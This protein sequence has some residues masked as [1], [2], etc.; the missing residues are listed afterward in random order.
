MIRAV[1]AA[2]LFLA[3]GSPLVAQES[4]VAIG[5][6]NTS[7]GLDVEANTVGG[8]VAS[9]RPNTGEYLVTVTATDA[10]VGASP[11]DFL[12]ETTI[13]A[14]S[15]GDD[16]SNGAVISVTDDVLTVRVRVADVED[17]GSVSAAVAVNASFF[18]VIRRV[19][20]LATV[21]EG[22]TRFLL[23]AGRMASS[24]SLV[25][26]F[27]L[28]GLISSSVR[29]NTGE[30]VLTLSKANA[31]VGDSTL[32][33]VVLL[34]PI[35]GDGDDKTVRGDVTNISSD[36]SASFV[37]CVDDVQSA[38][39]ANAA[40]PA[41][42]AFAY[43]IYRLDGIDLTGAPASTLNAALVSVAQNGTLVFG[44]SSIPG[45][46]ISSAHL[47]TGR[48]Q[49]DIV[50]PG[51]F[52]PSDADRFAPIASIRSAD[53]IDEIIK[54]T[55]SVPDVNTLRLAVAVDDVQDSGSP[56]GVNFSNASF[57]LSLVDTDPEIFHDLTISTRKAAATYRG[58][59]I[60]NKTG[61]G[62]TVR[63]NLDGTRLGRVYFK[64]KNVG[65]ASDV[66][67]VRGQAIFGRLNSHFFNT[68]AGRRNVTAQVKIG[69]AMSDDVRPG[70]V[71]RFEG[72]IRYKNAGS[73][74]NVVSKFSTIPRSGPLK[75]D[76]V[77]VLVKPR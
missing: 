64:S 15:S 32:D 16:I 65:H 45:A 2:L 53:L 68:T 42:R 46:T 10:F 1:F 39:P 62:Q 58:G 43:A 20:P 66:L 25:S 60:I 49:V 12:I 74:P 22:D 31:F 19:D 73:S 33:Y 51:Q 47:D 11:A 72:R 8:V 26:S 48:Y 63:L 55:V 76:L 6:V 70:E 14:S 38:V 41:N 28:N 75:T 61:A 59:G 3:G 18:F 37:F 69:S 50:A 30:Y 44:Q 52:S 67:R 5:N 34:T 29:V 77:R 13:E 56:A 21:S 17:S 24:G 57:T 71:E 9:S 4:L 36:D 23:S 40:V 35:G 54:T 7:G 27:A